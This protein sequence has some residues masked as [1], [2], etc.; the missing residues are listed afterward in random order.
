MRSWLLTAGLLLFMSFVS[1]NVFGQITINTFIKANN[2]TPFCVSDVAANRIPEFILNVS[3]GAVPYT[4]EVSDGTTSTLYNVTVEGT[5]EP[6]VFSSDILTATTLTIISVFDG[7]PTAV[8]PVFPAPLQFNVDQLPLLQVVSG[9]T[10]CSPGSVNI[11]LLATESGVDYHLFRDGNPVGVPVVGT[12]AAML[13]MWTENTVGTYTVT[14]TRGSCGPV[15]LTGTAIVKALPA[16]QVFAQTGTACSSGT[17]V[18]ND[19]ETGVDYILQRDG[20]NLPIV[21]S[22]IAGSSITFPVQTIPGVYTVQAVYTALPSCPL[23]LSGSLTVVNPNDITLA[24][25]GNVTSYCQGAV[26]SGITLYT[27]TSEAGNA[28]TLRNILTSTDFGLPKPGTN[29]PLS[30]NNVPV[31]DY[32]VVTTSGSCSESSNTISVTTK[33]L[34]T[35]TISINPANDERCENTIVPGGFNVT[36]N[37]T[38]TGPFNYTIVDDAAIPN[39]YPF[40]AAINTD[41]RAFDPSSTTTYTVSTVT[42]ATGCTNAAPS[43]GSATITVKKFS[44][45]I[46]EDDSEVCENTTVNLNAVPTPNIVGGYSYAWNTTQSSQAI[47]VI[48]TIAANTYNVTVTSIPDGCVVSA[49]KTITVNPLP[50]VSFTG[51]VPNYCFNSAPVTLTGTPVAPP[52]IGEFYLIKGA[53]APVW[54]GGNTFDASLVGDVNNV[55]NAQVYYTYTDAKG[56][57]NETAKQ[58]VT[59]NPLPTPSIVNLDLNYCQDSP[60]VVVTGNPVGGTF[61]VTGPAGLNYTAVPNSGTIT[62]SPSASTTGQTYNVHYTYSDISG[63]TSTVTEQTS[64]VNLNGGALTFTGLSAAYCQSD[65]GN[66]PISGLVNGA[67]VTSGQAVITGNGITQTPAQELTGEATF[68]PALAGVGSHTVTFTYTSSIGCTGVATMIVVVGADLT[69]SNLKSQFCADEPS[70]TLVGTPSQSGVTGISGYYEILPPTKPIYTVNNSVFVL[71]PATMVANESGTYHITYI[72]PDSPTAGCIARKTWQVDLNAMPDATIDGLRNNYCIND[73]PPSLLQQLNTMPGDLASF[74]GSGVSGNYFNPALAGVGPHVVSSHVVSSAGCVS[75]AAK[76]TN[77]VALPALGMV[78]LHDA[79]ETDAPYTFTVS[80]AAATGTFAFTCYSS[81]AGQNPLTHVGN[82]PSATFDPTVGEGVY[83]LEYSFEPDPISGT[84]CSQTVSQTVTVHRNDPVD[85]GGLSA[86]YCQNDSP[87]LLSGS[88]GAGSFTCSAPGNLGITDNSNG[89]ATFD[90]SALSPGNYTI[91]Y[92]YTNSQGCVSTSV[93]PV[94]INAKPIVYTVTGGGAYCKGA[95]VGASVQLSGSENGVVYELL[96]NG[97]SLSPAVTITGPVGGGAITFT[98]VKGIGT[99]SVRALSP[100][101]CS[102]DMAGNVTVSESELVLTTSKLNETC[103][104]SDNG[105]ASVAVSGGTAPYSYDWQ[106][107]AAATVSTT[108]DALNLVA[109]NYTVY[110]TDALGCTANKTVAITEPMALMLGL[111]TKNT[112]CDCSSSPANCDGAATVLASGGTSPYSITWSTGQTGGAV[113]KL[114]V[115]NYTVSVQ[116]YSMCTFSMPFSISV[117]GAS[118]TVSEKLASHQNVNCSGVPNG[119]LEVDASGGTGS[120][121]YSIDKVNWFASPLFTGLAAGSYT[122]SVREDA[123]AYCMFDTPSP[124]VITQPSALSLTELA[125]SHK[126]VTCFG[127]ADGQLEVLPT[128][129]SGAY[130]YSIDNGAFWQVSAK[131]TGLSNGNQYVW[132]RDANAPATCINKSLL[133]IYIDQPLPID[134]SYS[135]SNL[136]C[137]GSADGEI[138]LT[139]I[140]GNA[141]TVWGYSIDN[142]TNWQ[143]SGTFNGLNT[144]LYNALVR[145]EQSLACVSAGKMVAVSQPAAISATLLAGSTIDVACFGDNS[146]SFTLEAVPIGASLEYSITG[147]AT[148]PWQS[149]P[150]FS[151]LPVGNYDVSVKQASCINTNVL[152]VPINA[153]LSGLT[154]SGSTIT[155][156]TCSTNSTSGLANN[157]SVLVNISGGTAPYNYQ[158]VDAVTNIPVAVANGG[159]SQQISNMPKGSYRVMVADQGNCTVSVSYPIDQPGDWNVPFSKTNLTSVGANDGSIS[160]TQVNGGSAPYTISWSDGAAFDG[161]YN[162]TNLAVGSYSYTITDVNGCTYTQSIDIFDDT[163]LRAAIDKSDVNCFGDATGNIQVVISNGIPNYNV[164]LTG[165]TYDGTSI[166]QPITNVTPISNFGTL[167]AGNYVVTVT[168]SNGGSYSENVVINQP[169]SAVTM[170]VTKTDVTCNGAQDG[171]IN[172]SAAGG[173]P[174]IPGN[175]NFTIVPGP[176]VMAP[177]HQFDL[178]NIGTY[179]V[180]ASD[181]KGCT[182]SQVETIIQPNVLTVTVVAT[183]VLCNG[184]SDGTLKA[185]VSGRGG[186]TPYRYDWETYNGTAWVPY[187]LNDN[188]LVNGVSAGVYRSVITCLTDGCQ[189]TSA[190]VTVSQ[191]NVLAMDVVSKHVTTCYGDNSGYL[192]VEPYD[193]K[194]PYIFTYTGNATG[195]DSG[196]GPFEVDNLPA[197]SYNLEVKDANGCVL[198]DIEVISQPVPVTVSNIS[199]S[200]G[201]EN[202]SNGTLDLTIDG[203]IV[204]GGNQHYYIWLQ[205]QSM[206]SYVKTAVVPSGGSTVEQFTGLAPGH[207]DLIVRDINSTDPV[208]C[209]F[210][211]SFDLANIAITGDVVDATCLGIHSGQINNVAISGAE[212]GYT[213]SWSTLN[214]SGLNPSSLNQSNL[215]AGTYVLEVVDVVRGCTVSR[216]FDV[217]YANV[218][219]IDAS[220]TNVTCNGGSDGSV[221]IN[222]VSGA[223]GTVSYFWNG[224]AAM[225]QPSFLTGLSASTQQLEVRDGNNCAVTQTYVVDQPLPIT[226]NLTTSLANNNPYNRTISLSQLAGGNGAIADFTYTYS[227]PDVATWQA[228]NL[229]GMDVA[230]PATP[231]LTG[232]TIVGTYKVTVY[233]Q[234]NC[235]SPQSIA[236]DGDMALS[237]S[238]THIACNGSANG[239]IILNVSGGSGSYSYSWTKLE[240]AAFSANTKDLLGI[241]A[242]NYPVV[243]TDLVQGYTKTVTVPV[244]QPTAITVSAT[245]KPVYCAGASE[246]EIALTVSGGTGS[247]TYAWTTPNGSGLS[248]I[249]KNQ[250]GLTAGTFNVTV[251]DANSCS[252]ASSISVTEPLPL[253]FN[254]VMTNRNCNGT[255]DLAIQNMAGGSGNYQIVWTGPGITPAMQN[256]TVLSNLSAGTY[257]ATIHDVINDESKC[258][259]SQ[260]ITIAPGI[261][262]LSVVPIAQNC[263]SIPNGAIVVNVSGGIAPLTYLWTIVS[264]GGGNFIPTSLDQIGLLDGTYELTITDGVGCS[265]VVPNV[266][267]PLQPSF[268]IQSTVIPDHCT[269]NAGSIDVTVLPAS[270]NYSYNWLGAGVSTASED[271]SNLAKGFY[272]VT[273]HD[274]SSGCDETANIE[275][276]GPA[277]PLTVNLVSKIDVLCFGSNTGTIS[278]AASGGTAPYTYLW[279]GSASFAPGAVQTDLPAGDYSVVVEDANK[280]KSAP[281]NV[282]IGQP[283]NMLALL[284]NGVVDVAIHGDASGQISLSVTGGEGAYSLVWTGNDYLGNAIS[285]PN[286]DF[287]PTGLLAGFYNATVTDGNGCSAVLANIIV[288]QPLVPFTLLVNG[289]DATPCNGAVNG[290]IVV[291]TTGGDSPYAIRLFNSLGVQQGNKPVG[292]Y[293]FTN[294]A[295]DIYLVEAEDGNGVVLSQNVTINDPSPLVLTT[296]VANNATCADGN[297]GEI[298]VIVNGGLPN[299]GGFYKVSVSGIGYYNEQTNVVGGAMTLFNGLPA[300]AYLVRVIDDANN[301]GAFN[302]STDC[303]KDQLVNITKPDAIVSISDNPIVCNGDNAQI[304]FT[305]S[306]WANISANPLDVTLSN[307]NVVTVNSSPMFYS[308]IPTATEDVTITDVS[309]AG[310]K[311]GTGTGTA[312]VKVNNRP[313]ANIVG[314]AVICNGENTELKFYLTG[315]K[316]WTVTYTDGVS[317][318]T[319]TGIMLDLHPVTVSPSANTTYTLLQVTDNVCSQTYQSSDPTNQVDVTVNDLPSVVMTG[320]TT[321]CNGTST[322][323]E[324]SFN[325]GTPPYDVVVNEVGVG[326]FTIPNITVSPYQFAVSPSKTTIYELVS[327]KDDNG[328]KVDAT[329]TVTITVDPLPGEPGPISGNLTVCQGELGLTYSIAPVANATSYVWEI[330]AGFNLVSGGN[331]SVTIDIAN[332]ATT[333]PI[334]AYAVNGCGSSLTKSEIVVTVLPLPQKPVNITSSYGHDICQG[335]QGVV[336]SVDEVLGAKSY[337]WQLPAGL[338]SNATDTRTIL[339]DLDALQS[340][341]SGNVTVTAINDCGAGDAS[342]AYVVN[343]KPLPIVNAGSDQDVCGNSITLDGSLLSAGQIGKWQV[344]SGAAFV[345][346]PTKFDSQVTNLAQG[347]TVLEWRVTDSSTGCSSVDQ[348]TI[349]NNKYPLQ[350]L[351]DSYSTCNGHVTVHGTPITEVNGDKG[352]WSFINGSGILDDA[353]RPDAVVT[354]LTDDSSVLRWTVTHVSGCQ[355]YAE[356]E[357]TNNQPSAAIITNKIAVANICSND[358]TLMVAAVLVGKGIGS[359]SVVKGSGSFSNVTATSYKVTNIGQG[360]NIYRWTVVKNGCSLYDEVTVRN[361]LLTVSAGPDI[362]TCDDEIN[363][364]QGSN[365]LN[366]DVNTVSNW[367]VAN[368]GGVVQGS[369]SFVDASKYNTKV[370]DLAS[371]TNRLVWEINQKGCISR[372]TVDIISNKPI[373]AVVGA[374]FGICADTAQL[375]ANSALNGYWSVVS[376]SGIFDDATDPK[377]IVRGT[378]EGDN[379]YRW[380]IVKSGCSSTDDLIVEN[381]RV[382]VNA[383]KDFAVCENFTTLSADKP[384]K[385]TGEWTVVPGYGAGSFSPSNDILKPSVGGMLRG[386]NMFVW[387]VTNKDCASSDTVIVTN[388]ATS[389]PKASEDNPTIFSSS[390]PMEATPVEA[391]EIGTW[392]IISGGGTIDPKDIHNP[393]AVVTNLQK[394][395]NVFR[396]TVQHLDCT[397]FDEVTI[398]YGS[399]IIANAGANQSVCLSEAQLS[400]N[401]PG[402]SNGVWTIVKGF[403]VFDNDRD[404]QTKV[405]DLGLG[406]NI[407]QW[408]I[409]SVDTTTVDLVSITNNTPTKAVAGPDRT[410]C[411]DTWELEGNDPNGNEAKWTRITGNGTILNETMPNATV[412]GL[413]KGLNIFKY[414]ITKLTCKSIDSVRITNDLPTVAYAG[415]DTTLC[416][417]SVQLKPNT[418]TFGVGQWRVVEGSANVQGN[419]ALD[420][421]PGVSKLVWQISTQSCHSIDTLVIHN[422]TPTAAFAGLD[423]PICTDTVKLQGNLAERGNGRWELLTGTGKIDDPDNPQTIVRDIGRGSNRFRWV[424]D[425]KGCITSDDVEISNNLIPSEAGLDQVIC[426]DS[427]S[428]VASNPYPGTG[429]WGV[430]PGSGSGKVSFDKPQSS[431]GIVRNL[432]QGDNILTWTVNYLGCQSVSSVSITSNNPTKANAGK[433]QSQ[434]STQVVLGANEPKIMETGTWSL[435]NGD[436]TFDDVTKPFATVTNLNFGTNIFRW[437]IE[438]NGCSSFDDVAIEANMVTAVVGANQINHCSSSALLQANNPS[439]GV[440]T[441]SIVGGSGQATFVNANDPNT[442]VNNLAFGANTLRW[443]INNQSCVSSAEMVITN[444]SPN[445][446]YAGNN[447]DLCTNTVV[448]DATPVTVGQQGHWEILSGTATIVDINNPKSTVSNLSKGDNVFRWRVQNGTCTND[449]EVLIVNNEPS[450]PY[451]GSDEVVCSDSYQLKATSPEYGQGLWTIVSGAATIGKPDAAETTITAI[452]YGV[453]TFKWTVSKGQCQLSDNVTITNSSATIA[454]AGADIQDCK[455]YATLQAGTTFNGSGT[456]SLVSGKATIVSPTTNTTNLTGLGF[457]ENIFKWSIKNGNCISSDL[458]SVFNKMPDQSNAGTDKVICDDITDLAANNPVSGTGKWVVISGSGQFDTPTL[459]NTKVYNVGFGDNEYEWTI[460]YGQCSTKDV[461][462]VTSRKAAPYAGDD[463]VV[464]TPEYKLM[465]GNPG[466]LSGQWSVIGGSGTFENASFFNTKVTGLRQG[467]N[468]YR[469]TMVVNGCTFYDDVSIAYKTA[470]TVD[471]RTDVSLGCMPLDVQFTD[472]SV[473]GVSYLWDFGDGAPSTEHSPQHTYTNAG[474]FNVKLSVIGVDGVEASLNQKIVVNPLPVAGFTLSASTVFVPGGV[475]HFYNMSSGANTYQWL[476]GDGGASTTLNP[477]YEY[478][479][480]GVYD[481]S[482]LVVNEF[483]CRDSLVQANAVEVIQQGFVSFPNA[484]TPKPAGSATSGMGNEVFKPKYKDVDEYHLQIFDR[485]GQLI[486]ESGDITVGW[487]GTYKNELS[488]QDVYV[489]KSWGR[490]ISGKEFRTTGNV[491]LVR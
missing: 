320:T 67:A 146:G 9:G 349:S 408:A 197:G 358:T 308:Y 265:V 470:P 167:K 60:D 25:V 238:V 78:G 453:N 318:F 104:Y 424:V 12:G 323:L 79:C 41:T 168:D 44:V 297:D 316:P 405:R 117:V 290:R 324:F 115:G 452:G 95:A 208:T 177:S 294:L 141:A 22:G 428:L 417:D 296:L 241:T 99:Y 376:G 163:A 169:A 233:D 469:W 396:W 29:G 431:F 383:G 4:V 373:T 389:I 139:P 366:V 179:T 181:E 111:S 413:S 378:K 398:K 161:L 411:F 204:I 232:L 332:I 162:R 47:S 394:G 391:D 198:A 430:L 369:A 263:S 231:L 329:G 225:G 459:Y 66:Y 464:Y 337:Q 255:G 242:G 303:N 222:N 7:V 335:T 116:D 92:T 215:S 311:K 132:V 49:S 53:A 314:D 326:E 359:W 103:D 388:N 219:S 334:R 441:W 120:F 280:C 134:F 108:F 423:Q 466:T 6:I 209:Q 468:T 87:V 258:S 69:V 321:I 18:L 473:G 127:G 72:L 247:Y 3:G 390:H 339:V 352:M 65:V 189:A 272:T 350:A 362:T 81:I 357:V 194:A 278:I 364:L 136:T 68:S 71:D 312:S 399:P 325:S 140:G 154:I 243:V 186:G 118:V 330:P 227:G 149:S 489:Y 245:V 173:T 43:V 454:N 46:V 299:S 260:T 126:N 436:G 456:W 478:S 37:F 450:A 131:F 486:F 353:T 31:G 84:G 35:A 159:N 80:N 58:T 75:N 19:S 93:K 285:I 404:Y 94:Q 217:A 170:T 268:N 16:D 457:G 145:D 70:V 483:G 148:R 201:C 77:V 479:E 13:S 310:C 5:D 213:F 371:T 488:M 414:E 447:L 372:D 256:L 429:T 253:S 380:N 83:T 279:T 196:N 282:S 455:D 182:V 250:T 62:I 375:T 384:E 472:Y 313:T 218:L 403:G 246:G 109:G 158:W 477:M 342:A 223:T 42:D 307:G 48:P 36:V 166:N 114:G 15:A 360:D 283:A 270:P 237:T 421:T 124:I 106:N 382:K 73:T 331:E 30:W 322:N 269:A 271:Q 288:R 347:P 40:S 224:S 407:F 23:V 229:V 156:I 341:I 476:F 235:P 274:N 100:L 97:L 348:V 309:V 261:N 291:T 491:M 319:E 461:V 214:G 446:A 101:G 187:L 119:Q 63:C 138:I 425:N 32:Q 96:L 367:Y 317:N 449:D 2:V 298:V 39:S 228:P 333:A 143:N 220:K 443:T 89:T 289:F 52:G 328:C 55:V 249:S 151:N 386:V 172:V 462:T 24:A 150:T 287:M 327:V 50:V 300:G 244:N 422:N 361:N 86:S 306:N 28:Y 210:T 365:H 445:T 302:T 26:S 487:D 211:Y 409:S 467:V 51:L 234:R 490:Y 264:N 14:A 205:D 88:F 200:I 216:S 180:Y 374:D 230:A 344:V 402:T 435:R 133:P 193:G 393:F 292:N 465:A 440:G 59:V 438:N 57:Y 236:I 185:T 190:P 203:G 82:S 273:V 152:T 112:T 248:P 392:S 128:G 345:V 212:A 125:A 178:L 346:D 61:T 377:T 419:W 439:P 251:T 199:H 295:P 485:W 444:N 76:N 8:D 192:Y 91:T 293:E 105:Q 458:V 254:L 147:A 276:T 239:A 356:V 406:E 301:D 123:N 363:E 420:L 410:I 176:S 281:F 267:V 381:K 426:A 129:G 153:P 354:N 481:V 336:F 305:V 121:E 226:Y 418:P 379:I 427:A 20:I 54:L 130:E 175:Y 463:A 1:S 21:E 27:N 207:Y 351:A 397:S 432:E 137:N 122:V 286:D 315:Q 451:A 484:F 385:G 184:G 34:P 474:S 188:A 338:K 368:V 416:T 355:S 482:L 160:I 415:K 340:N 259:L 155:N 135:K 304:T 460:A 257:V 240:D 202:P 401:S 434:C 33:A 195:T 387:T 275:V 395:T 113:G 206:V 448:L 38:G 437:T 174:F 10:I 64:I 56:C 400:A 480:V 11:G 17:V 433:D 442:T 412:I 90:P 74:S 157:G 221:I 475:V 98:D 171:I 165:L 45:V 266:V 102:M 110:V 183:D 284:L 142:G 343:I 252:V 277:L 370:L 107:G 85:F 164:L 262:V 471:F 144:S 191:N